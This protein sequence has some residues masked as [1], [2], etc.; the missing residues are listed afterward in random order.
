MNILIGI[1]GVIS[2]LLIMWHVITPREW[3]I[4]GFY[5]YPLLICCLIVGY[6]LGVGL[7]ELNKISK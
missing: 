6:S 1:L 5:G 3:W 7:E 2:T 4:E